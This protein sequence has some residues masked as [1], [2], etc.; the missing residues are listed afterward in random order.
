MDLTNRSSLGFNL[1]RFSPDRIHS[2]L[3]LFM[4]PLHFARSLSVSE[5]PVDSGLFD[6]QAFAHEVEFVQHG[7]SS[8]GIPLGSHLHETKPSPLT[9]LPVLDNADRHDISGTGEKSSQLGF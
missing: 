4:V 2:N 5:T 6:Q 8:P 7:D 3:A 1:Y 9:G